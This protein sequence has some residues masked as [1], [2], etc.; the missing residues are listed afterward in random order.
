MDS[1]KLMVREELDSSVMI[2]ERISVRRN[3]SGLYS[4]D[5][6]II[7]TYVSVTLKNVN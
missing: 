5:M 6:R 2:A 3:Y 7:R 1:L 4:R